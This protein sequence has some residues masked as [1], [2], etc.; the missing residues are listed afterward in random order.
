MEEEAV[1]FVIETAPLDVNP[2]NV[3]T[4]VILACDA[5]CKVPVRLVAVKLRIPVISLFVSTTNAFDAE[6]VPSVIPVI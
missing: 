6:A 2:V 4:E 1:A 5:V 3:P